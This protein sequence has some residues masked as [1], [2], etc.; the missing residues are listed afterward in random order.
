MHKKINTDYTFELGDWVLGSLGKR[1][2]LSGNMICP[3]DDNKMAKTILFSCKANAKGKAVWKFKG[4]P[5]EKDS[6]PGGIK[7]KPRP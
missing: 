3:T 7:C 6:N 5:T 2:L 1:F 4:D